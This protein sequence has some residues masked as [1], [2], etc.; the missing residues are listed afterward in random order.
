MRVDCSRGPLTTNPLDFWIQ[1][2]IF[3]VQCIGFL[4]LAITV[5]YNVLK[6]RT[7]H[8]ARWS[9]LFLAIVDVLI[10]ACLVPQSL[11]TF[12]A[13]Y[14]N[15]QFRRF[16]QLARIR[17]YAFSNQL[18]AVDTSIFLLIIIEIYLRARGST[19]TKALFGGKAV[20]LCIAT[21]ITGALM[22]SSFHHFS[23]SPK[24]WFNCSDE[25][26]LP[27]KMFSKITM[28]SAYMTKD[29][30]I[31]LHMASA[32]LL[33]FIPTILVYFL[34]YRI[35]RSINSG[36]TGCDVANEAMEL[37]SSAEGLLLQ[38]KKITV[39]LPM[40]AHSFALTHVLSVVP[41]V[42]EF[43]L[44]HWLGFKGYSITISIMNALLICGKI[45]NF[46]LLYLSCVEM[47]RNG[48]LNY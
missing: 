21:A 4:T 27:T 30:F 36:R 20:F 24:I 41:F 3:P 14:E 1:H 13:L 39:Y 8:V 37:F 25:N 42:W 7:K 12:R 48:L 22:I 26:G 33:I 45:A 18:S 2:V 5:I 29:L 6:G 11:G 9:L 43:F 19:M 47:G 35:T 17:L 40:V 15:E 23:Y 31:W 38:R 44:F 32:L 10:F 46:G 16:Y 34:V 28:N